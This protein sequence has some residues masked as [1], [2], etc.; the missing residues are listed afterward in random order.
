[1]GYDFNADEIFEMAEHIDSSLT[2]DRR[3]KRVI[4]HGSRRNLRAGIQ[5]HAWTVERG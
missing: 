1:M 4:W 2:Q 3:P 5:Q